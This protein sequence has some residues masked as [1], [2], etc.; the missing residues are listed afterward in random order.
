MLNALADFV[1]SE[2]VP[3]AIVLYVLG[4]GAALLVRGM[5]WALAA[6]VVLLLILAD[7][8]YGGFL[9]RLWNAVFP[10]S[11]PDRVVSIQW[12]VVPLLMTWGV[13]CAPMVF[14]PVLAR[15]RKPRAVM[16]VMGAAAAVAVLVPAFGTSTVLTGMQN[17]V[18]GNTY[19][20]QA[21][22]AAIAAMDRAL[23]P[24]TRVLSDTG[25]DGG[26]WIDVLTRDVEWAPIA[27]TRGYIKAGSI[28]PAVDP[29]VGAIAQ[30]CSAPAAA[31]AALSGIGAV[32]VGSHQ[33]YDA[34]V[35]WDASC[36]AALPGVHELARADGGHGRTAWVFAVDPTL[37]AQS[38]S[39]S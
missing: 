7:T 22:V 31:R 34:K 20:T 2:L 11:G 21:D 29:K 39:G 15:I 33:Q 30:A 10:W 36:I 37:Q 23:P 26:Q 24:G 32:F 3:P 18:A 19:T 13:F 8:G 5:R 6:Y 14:R 25:V 9:M 16:A 35:R 12:F 17:Y 38:P 4:L 28:A 1:R 27:F